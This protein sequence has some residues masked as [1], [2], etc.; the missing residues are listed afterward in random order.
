MD[1]ARGQRRWERFFPLL[2]AA[3]IAAAYHNSFG[4]A[5]VFDDVE[6]VEMRALHDLWS[7]RPLIG[8]TRPLAGADPSTSG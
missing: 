8:T 7:L 6:I 2:V 4:A 1:A 5:F 3:A